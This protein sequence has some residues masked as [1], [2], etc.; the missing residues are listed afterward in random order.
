M[1]GLLTPSPDLPRPNSTQTVKK[2]YNFFLVTIT[3]I[4]IKKSRCLIFPK[5]ILTKTK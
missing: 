5:E 2:I 1:F 4:S 3:T